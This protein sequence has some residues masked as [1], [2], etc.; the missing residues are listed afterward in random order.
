MKRNSEGPL[1]LYT[2]G[3]A[4]LFLAGFLMLVI[5]GARTY[6]DVAVNQT[7]NNDTRAL[8]SYLS[9]CVKSSD[10]QGGISVE[11]SAYGSV[12]TIADASGYA[13]QIYQNGEELLEEYHVLGAELRPESADVLG[14][15]ATF[16]VEMQGAELLK[17]TTDAGSVL[18]RLRS[19]EVPE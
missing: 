13:L 11:E 15:T 8:L 12:L 3:I 6:R 19:E 14:T 17:I 4:A 1:G 5:L 9:T 7:K 2:I 16:T 10:T 18:L